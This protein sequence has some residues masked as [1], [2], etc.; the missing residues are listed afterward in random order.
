[1]TVNV[2]ILLGF[3]NKKR[4]DPTDGSI[5][6]PTGS[7]RYRFSTVNWIRLHNCAFQ[8]LHCFPCLIPAHRMICVAFRVLCPP[9]GYCDGDDENSDPSAHGLRV[10]L[11]VRRSVESVVIKRQL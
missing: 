4:C 1:M 6:M 8:A 2:V 5:S 7:F 11:F 9:Y 10:L 3:S